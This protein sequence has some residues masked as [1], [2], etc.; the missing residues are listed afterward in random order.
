MNRGSPVLSRFG[1][2]LWHRR[3]LLGGASQDIPHATNDLLDRE[4]LP[5]DLVNGFHI[6]QVSARSAGSGLR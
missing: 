3:S 6:N 2:R 4:R 5:A 1:E